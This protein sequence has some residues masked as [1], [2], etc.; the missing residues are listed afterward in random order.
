MRPD[1]ADHF[2][3]RTGRTHEVSGPAALSFALALA[4][5]RGGTT[6]WAREDWAPEQLNPVGISPY[7]DPAK[8]LIAKGKDQLEV[9]AVAEEAL[10]S[11][12]V[13]LV[14]MELSKPLDLTAGRRLQLAAEAGKSTGLCLIQDG[15]GSNA[16]ETRWH[17]APVF[18]ESGDSTH[19]I[20][21]LKKNKS[22]TLSKWEV[23]WDAET[24]R[25]RLV[26]DPA[27]RQGLARA[28]P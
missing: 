22:G 9:L 13:T 7:L 19:Q 5:A 4:N 11:G 14:V 24:R 23:R 10:R 20:W 6:L 12:A 26:S 1:L 25:I 18:S 21:D 16:A 3:P 15:M 2:P 28:H 17:C 8:L 27:K